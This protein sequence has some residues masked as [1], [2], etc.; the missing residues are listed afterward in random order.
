MGCETKRHKRAVADPGGMRGM[1]PHPPQL[2][3]K[4]FERLYF[5]HCE[6]TADQIRMQFGVIGRTGPGMRQV[7]GFGDR[8]TGRGTFGAN[9]GRAIVTSGDFA[10]YVYT[11]AAT[12]P[13][14]QITLG[15]L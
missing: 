7:V 1:R 3:Q 4:I 15:V 13:S 11:F 8:C 2:G 12:R 9:L 6:E 14:S 5:G 10:A